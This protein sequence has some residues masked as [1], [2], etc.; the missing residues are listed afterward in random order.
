[1]SFVAGADTVETAINAVPNGYRD[2]YETDGVICM[3]SVINPVTAVRLLAEADASVD[4][5]DNMNLS[6]RLVSYWDCVQP[7]AETAARL[8]QSREI[9][10]YNDHLF[11]KEAG[12][13]VATDW[14]QD[15]PF[16]PFAGQQITA[17]WIALT[18]VRRAESAVHYVRGSHR[19]GRFYQPNALAMSDTQHPDFLAMEP[20]PNYFE[21]G[22]CADEDML[23]WDMEPGDVLWHNGLTFHGAEA[24]TS[25]NGATRAGLTVRFL[26]DDVTWSP[27]PFFRAPA[28][29]PRVMPGERISGDDTFP[30]LWPRR[31]S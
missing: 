23:S 30:L 13:S 5:R 22:R 2:R 31:A 12:K 4:Y 25:P 28:K 15:L 24:N 21:A 3:R 20:C 14:H 10:L 16:W 11:V 8:L 9:R 6:E 27:R 26:G 29:M 7:L 19:S 18:P 1:M 17:A